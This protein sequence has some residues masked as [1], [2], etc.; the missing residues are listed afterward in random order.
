MNDIF[1]GIQLLQYGLSGVFLVL[2]LFYAIITLLM[3]ALPYQSENDENKQ[4]G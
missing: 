2:I 1:L 4:S 3:R